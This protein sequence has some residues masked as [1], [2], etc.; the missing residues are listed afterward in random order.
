[1]RVFNCNIPLICFIILCIIQFISLWNITLFLPFLCIIYIAL[2]VNSIYNKCYFTKLTTVVIYLSII[3]LS[4]IINER[5]SLYSHNSR[6]YLLELFS[7][8]LLYCLF[9]KYYLHELRY[10]LYFVAFVTITSFFLFSL[11]LMIF[12]VRLHEAQ[13]RG[14]L[15]I[16]QVRYLYTPLGFL[17]NEWVTIILCLLPFPI[18]GILVLY[19]NNILKKVNKKICII[20]CFAVILLGVSNIL[21]TFSR[22]GLIAL[23]ILIVI[24][25]ISFLFYRIFTYKIIMIFNIVIVSFFLSFFFLFPTS[26]TMTIKQSNS[27]IRSTE[28]R[29][30][31]LKES[32]RLFE[33]NEI[34]GI[35]AKNYALINSA[36]QALK[37]NPT[38]TGKINNSFVQL[39]VEQG[40]VGLLIYVL[41]GCYYFVFISKK[42]KHT[43]DKKMKAILCVLLAT[44]V[45]IIIR[46]AMYSS[47]FYNVWIL[48]F[49]III[50][51]LFVDYPIISIS[52]LY[53]K[54]LL[55]AGLFVISIIACVHIKS[56]KDIDLYEKIITTEG[57]L[58]CNIET[59]NALLY[60]TLALRNAD[61]NIDFKSEQCDIN[62]KQL[63]CAI[64]LYEKAISLN[65]YDALFYHNL[66]WLYYCNN[67]KELALKY[68]Q[69]AI[70]F[71]P[72]EAVYYISN[73]LLLETKNM[74]QAIEVYKQALLLEPSI[75]FSPFFAELSIRYPNMS[76]NM[77]EDV[78]NFLSV[79]N[80]LNY[81][82]ITEAKMG[83]VYL[84]M[85]KYDL[86]RIYLSNAIKILPNLSR[87]WCYLGIISI[88]LND[89]GNIE[90]N[91]KKSI[92][93]NMSDY[94]PKYIL[95]LYYK[96]KGDEIRS[97]SF[98]K[99]AIDARQYSFHSLQCNRLYYV[100]TVKNDIFPSALLDYITPDL[101][102][103][104]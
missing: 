26:L 20:I 90:N 68:L 43:S 66:G 3:F 13:L 98:M 51:T 56:M 73:G 84:K 83:A 86:S 23:I 29:I 63:F 62:S 72:N 36:N 89:T 38:F 76:L 15:D 31:Q 34:F 55:F 30:A 57:I 101:E 17:S 93:L 27:H 41:G 42:I 16:S 9:S 52:R 4:G 58:S 46:E 21:V 54:Y 82:P 32:Y 39:L 44:V 18:I 94:F 35:G 28:G 67:Q 61:F 99:S 91:L 53:S 12:T 10:K 33:N 95:S 7:V 1:M 37:N 49:L 71:N 19:K 77:I 100:K 40:V 50:A 96:E 87:P 64:A 47:L 22:A 97:I 11:G 24:I 65:P 75:L 70:Q 14:F 8:I 48:F 60:S 2:I 81:S 74:E 103:K 6:I 104:Y 102:Y 88:V 59:D 78:L 5:C 92:Y 85:K 79:E 69:K 80:E 25:D 45:S